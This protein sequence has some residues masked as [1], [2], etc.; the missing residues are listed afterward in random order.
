MLAQASHPLL[1]IGDTAMIGRVGAEALA[2]RAIGAAL[3]GSVYWIFSFLTFGTTSLVGHHYGARDAKACGETFLHALFLA[4]TGGLVVSAAG[5]WLAA[6]LYHLM[7]A[8]PAVAEPGIAYFRIVISS[9]PLTLLIYACTGF[10]RGIQNTKLPMVIAFVI[11]IVHLSLDYVLIYGNFGLPALGLLGAAA[12]A[13]LA[14]LVGAM[15]CLGVF[16]FSKRYAEYRA[17]DWRLTRVSLRP[18]FSIGRELAIRTGALRLSLVFVTAIAARMGA[19]TL[20]A[21]EIVFQLF[22]LCSD[23]VDGLAIAGQALAA[24]YLGANEEERAYRMGMTLIVAGFVT[25]LIFAAGFAAAWDFIVRF[26]TNNTEVLS[27]LTG[28][29][30]LLVCG[31]QPFNGIVFVLDG[32][33]I[34]ARD[35]R[36]LMWAMLAGAFGCLLPIAGSALLFDWGLNGLLIGIGALMSWR[37]LTNVSR[38]LGGKWSARS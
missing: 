4:L 5:A 28:G 34:G 29:L 21:Y 8:Q 27:L 1:N 25:G 16:L 9:A 36:Y 26:F 11:A 10:L 22:M 18:L 20:A 6:P 12:A 23:V 30:I 37:C 33:L 38:F 7:G 19:A 2:A 13:W 35:T 31:I 24:K 32:L 14:Q 17:I 15:T 3:M